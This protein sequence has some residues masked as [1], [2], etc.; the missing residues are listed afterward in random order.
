MIAA[1]DTESN[2]PIRSSQGHKD[3]VDINKVNQANM[4]LER[5]NYT[6]SPES[7]IMGTWLNN[8]EVLL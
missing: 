7:D 1:D 3:D 6:L 2:D 8:S 5:D 4:T